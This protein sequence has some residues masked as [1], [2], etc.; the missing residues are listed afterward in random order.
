MT[1]PTPPAPDKEAALRDRIEE[2]GRLLRETSHLEPQ[3]QKALAELIQEMSR[4]LHPEDDDH[5]TAQLVAHS[6]D[7]IRALHEQQ[8]AGLIASARHRLE[9]VAAR[10]EAGAPVVTGVVRRL[11]DVLAGIGV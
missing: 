9:E 1:S 8:D 7:L 6:T 4:S 11:I 2:C 3:A 5:H 10:A